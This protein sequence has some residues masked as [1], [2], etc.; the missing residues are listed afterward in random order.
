[1]TEEILTGKFKKALEP[2]R[3]TRRGMGVTRRTFMQVL[4]AGIVITVTEES[5][6]DNGVVVEVVEVA[7]RLCWQGFI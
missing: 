4:G 1:M 5:L 6:W 3:E 7:T 2:P